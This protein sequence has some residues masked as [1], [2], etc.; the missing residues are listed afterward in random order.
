MLHVTAAIVHTNIKESGKTVSNIMFFPHWLHC[1]GC[2]FE[3]HYDSIMILIG[4]TFVVKHFELVRE[5]SGLFS[6]CAVVTER[7]RDR[8]RVGERGRKDILMGNLL[9]GK[10]LRC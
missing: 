3:Y 7:V 2:H 8:G 1:H 10:A 6:Q 4:N 9:G 5:E